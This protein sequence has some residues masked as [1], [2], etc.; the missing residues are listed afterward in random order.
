MLILSALP[1]QA[2]AWEFG[3]VNTAKFARQSSLDV[4][5]LPAAKPGET[6]EDV[7]RTFS[8][9]VVAD[10]WHGS[11]LATIPTMALENADRII[12]VVFPPPTPAA[13]PL[14]APSGS[15]AAGTVPPPVTPKE[16]PLSPDLAVV[17]RELTPDQPPLI[18]LTRLILSA[19][20][21]RHRVAVNAV[22][23]ARE[24]SIVVSV[25]PV[26]FEAPGS[27]RETR[28]SQVAR[29]SL[30]P[31]KDAPAFRKQPLAIRKGTAFLGR[32]HDSDTM[33]AIWNGGAQDG[34]AWLE[35]KV[36]GYPRAFVFSVDC[37]PAADGEIQLPQS[38]WRSVHITNPLEK[39]IIQLAPAKA[40]PFKIA[41]DLPADAVGEGVRTAGEV[42]LSL[43]AV[44][45]ADFQSET[46]HSVWTSTEERQAIFTRGKAEAP[47]TFAVN[48]KVQDWEI[49]ASGLGFENVDVVAEV[50]VRVPGS[51][52]ALSD[53]RLFVMDARAPV[54]EAPPSMTVVVGRP[55]V[56][57]VR[58]TDD[59]R[60]FA[61]GPHLAGV[62]G[63][64]RVE[65]GLDLKG[66]GKPAD[67]QPAI[68]LGDGTYEVR[69]D[70]A[71]LPLGDRFPL[72]I[73][74]VDRAGL[75]NTPEPVWLESAPVVAKN[76][77]QGRVILEGLGEAGVSVWLDGPGDRKAATSK[78]SGAFEFVDLE[79]GDYTLQASGP[80]RNRAY[81][82]EALKVSVQS[83]PAP[84][85]SVTLQ[86]K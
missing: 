51:Q 60:E 5:S 12:P 36:D 81:R 11:P 46:A 70:T 53:R 32:G 68:N 67:W 9:A 14:P 2:T 74:A 54:V 73:R 82:S 19:E 65:W 75:E 47:A 23:R 16:E 62:S 7:W 50:S 30:E 69:V 71:K 48:T 43:R 22:W 40:L 49:D 20:H 86:L 31:L 8:S 38:D 45:D 4:F 64:A 79:P 6:R 76:S 42:M 80:V 58:V 13:A 59:P 66:V 55:L 57:P 85:A 33:V 25:K 52:Q 37:S 24:R 56:V 63:V 83:P 26:A 41:I 61:G 15:T 21:P 27:T 84:A 28:S 17:V 78:A 39:E 34:R 18:S 72:F 35:V 29:V 1:D 10:R 3:V 44:S 77:I